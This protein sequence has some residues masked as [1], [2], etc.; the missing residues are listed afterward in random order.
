MEPKKD[1]AS[2]SSELVF[3]MTN[4]FNF[5]RTQV[6]DNSLAMCNLEKD[7][8]AILKGI[9]LYLKMLISEGCY[10]DY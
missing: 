5:L 10:G 1:V 8:H 4:F 2:S 7:F 3:L 9:S 6:F